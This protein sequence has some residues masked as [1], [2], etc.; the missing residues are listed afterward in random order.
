MKT[1]M[2]TRVVTFLEFLLDVLRVSLTLPQQV[3]VAV[4]FDNVAPCTL[5][6]ERR[7]LAA[8]MFGLIDDVPESAR[9]VIALMKGA[10]IGGTWI[11]SL[12]LLYRACTA[13]EAQRLAIG[14]MAFA[15]IVAPDKATG[16]QAKRYALGGA[17]SCRDIAGLIESETEDGFVIRRQDGRRVS[18]EVIAATRGGSA[19]RGRS[20]LAALMDESSFFRDEE[21][22]INDSELYRAIAPR[23]MVGG[24]LAIISTC[25][26]KGG[27]LFDLVERNHGAPKGAIAAICPTELMR[28]DSPELAQLIA[29]ETIRDEAN[30]NREYRC[31]PLDGATTSTFFDPSSLD[32][33]IDHSLIGAA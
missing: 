11:S 1:L 5:D 7:E 19:L 15:P 26:I 18:I 10:R 25:W 9:A 32:S 8:A 29:E 28:P 3:L 17:Q 24:K 23:V 27:L 2:K 13:P 22:S 33:M 6:P 20:M 31:I 14:E 4:A 16:R 21:Y 12:Y 30:A